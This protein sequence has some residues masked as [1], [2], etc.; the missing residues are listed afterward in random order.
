VSPL[1]GSAILDDEDDGDFSQMELM[2]TCHGD[3]TH[4]QEI[5]QSAKKLQL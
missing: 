3:D 5:W 1:A 2:S 4:Q